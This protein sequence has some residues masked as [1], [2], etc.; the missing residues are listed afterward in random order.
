VILGKI[1]TPG[2]F[3]NPHPARREISERWSHQ[4][5]GQ[6]MR[7]PVYFILRV[8]RDGPL[9]PARLWWCDTEPGVPDNKLDRGRFSIYPRAAIGGDEVD[10][11]LIFDR[12]M[13]H[14]DLRPGYPPRHW[15]YAQPI[16]EERYRSEFDRLRWAERNRPAHPVLQPRRKVDPAQL[17]LPDFTRENNE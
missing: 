1:A 4:H 17:P 2:E 12:T 9:L 16:S 14:R 5:T 13:S 3:H 11:E 8:R 6:P 10:P 7:T 15:K